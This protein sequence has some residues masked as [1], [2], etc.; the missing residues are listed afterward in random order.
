MVCSIY[1]DPQRGSDT[2]PMMQQ[3]KLAMQ[4]DRRRKGGGAARFT[5]FQTIREG[6]MKVGE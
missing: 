6:T 3:V 5:L 4:G 2:P 1:T